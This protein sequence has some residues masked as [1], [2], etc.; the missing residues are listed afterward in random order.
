MSQYRNRQAS[1]RYTVKK[2][3]YHSIEQ[4]VDI[5][6]SALNVPDYERISISDSVQRFS[7]L[8]YKNNFKEIVNQL[9]QKN[10]SKTINENISL[11]KKLYN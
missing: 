4:A 3:Q 8:V 11:N 2:Y 9:L 6:L 10:K 7:S 5:I 1:K